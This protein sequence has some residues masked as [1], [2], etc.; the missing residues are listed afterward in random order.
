MYTPRVGIHYRGGTALMPER[1][2]R[3]PRSR[4]KALAETRLV[5][6]ATDPTS[7]PRVSQLKKKTVA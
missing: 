1:W 4:A 3:T 5:A 6:T 7:V 2:A